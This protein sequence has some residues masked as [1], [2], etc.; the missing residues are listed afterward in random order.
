MVES[1]G[2]VQCPRSCHGDAFGHIFAVNLG[3]SWEYTEYALAFATL[4]VSNI[5][6]R[7]TGI[8]AETSV[9]LAEAAAGLPRPAMHCTT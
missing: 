5:L 8:L 1:F 4:V 3:S 6:F 9:G 7:D 2:D